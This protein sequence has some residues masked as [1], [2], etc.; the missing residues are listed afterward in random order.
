MR[1]SDWS[2]DV[3]SS[4]LA[5]LPLL[6]VTSE[7]RIPALPSTPTVQESG[8]PFQANVWWA[9]F[10]P[11]DLPQSVRERLNQAINKALTDPAL[12]RILTDLAATSRALSSRSEARRVGK[13]CVS[14]CRYRW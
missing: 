8:V 13:E 5:R 7:K 11:R 9:V 2:S 1:I 4:D 3:C 10:G 12:S 6:A 14:T